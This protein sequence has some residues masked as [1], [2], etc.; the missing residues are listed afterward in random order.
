MVFAAATL[1]LTFMH[2]QRVH[3]GRDLRLGAR[4]RRNRTALGVALALIGAFTLVEFVAGLM[5]GSLALLADA[6]HML[7]DTGSLG[8]AFLAAWLASRPATPRRS[9]GSGRAEILAALVNGIALVAVSIWIFV[10][11]L[12]R[13]DDPPGVPG[14]WV[15][16]VGVAGLAVNV[17]AAWILARAGTESLNVRAALRHVLADLLGSIGVI[18]AGVVVL[19]TG[20]DYADP[21]AALAIGVLV[22]ASSWRI[23]REAVG[24]LLEETPA[25]IDAE[26]VGRALAS[27]DGVVEVHDLHIWTITSGFPALAAHVLVVPGGDCHG[28]RRDLELLLHERFGLDHTTLQVEH[29]DEDALVRIGPSFRRSSP[30][31]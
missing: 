10:A 31:R 1:N 24:I 28:V 5:A 23:L 30:L 3:P 17:A 6:A 14:G 20:W 9:F 29:A 26:E 19:T 15:L 12:G 21:L 4:A 2:G 18:V 7:S 13:L 16:G 22:L 8:L 25:G 11:A 27:A